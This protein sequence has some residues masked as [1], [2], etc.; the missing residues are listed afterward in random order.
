MQFIKELSAEGFTLFNVDEKKLPINA[1]GY[2]LK[3]WSSISATDVKR[4][5]NYQ[6]QLWG[7]RT[8]LHSNNRYIMSLDFDCCGKSVDGIRI[9]CDYTK[10][11]MKEYMDYGILDGMFESSTKGNMN[12]LIDYTNCP[13]LLTMLDGKSKFKKK[14]T[15]LEILFGSGHQQVIPPSTTKCKISGVAENKRKFLNSQPLLI[16]NEE[17]SNFDF[18]KS[19]FEEEPQHIKK[20]QRIGE[21]PNVVVS[22][23]T[24]DAMT[25]DDEHIDLLFNVIKNE[26]NQK[27]NSATTHHK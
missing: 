11:K 23:Q 18:I 27:D 22:Q 8:G 5:H 21:I 9:G 19:L 1:Q 2:S 4:E 16:L 15:D 13:S 17:T 10:N 20:K 6:S 26:K 7:I 24:T 3:G 12:V 25:T 14:D